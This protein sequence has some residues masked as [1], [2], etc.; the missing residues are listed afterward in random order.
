MVPLAIVAV[1]VAVMAL[2]SATRAFPPPVP[3]ALMLSIVGV[4]ALVWWRVDRPTDLARERRTR[5][6][7]RE[8]GYDLRASP[9]GCPECGAAA[10]A[11]SR[12]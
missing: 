10:P 9:D 5:G 4:G 7:C 1:G 2:A 6:L 8:C 11:R 3:L 12:R